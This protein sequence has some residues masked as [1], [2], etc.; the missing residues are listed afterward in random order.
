ME[1]PSGGNPGTLKDGVVA[2][3]R[4]VNDA[5]P[6]AYVR[7]QHDGYLDVDG[8]QDGST[9]ETYAALRLDIDNWR[10]SGVPFF[11]RTGKCL[12]TTQ[13]E[14][15][16]VFKRPPRLGFGMMRGRGAPLR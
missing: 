8:V 6:A 13:T 15:R 4:G 1:P 5:D 2:A 16:L 12:A 14:L 11:I 10:W 7:G 3:F 9:T